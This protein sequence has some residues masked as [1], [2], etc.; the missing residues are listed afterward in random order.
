MI[1]KEERKIYVKSKIKRFKKIWLTIEGYTYLR[2]QKKIK[3]KSMTEILDDLI[4]E[5]INKKT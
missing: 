5:K 2:E 4:K 3:E 1:Q